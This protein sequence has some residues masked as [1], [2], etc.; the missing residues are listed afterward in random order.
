MYSEKKVA[1]R[2]ALAEKEL[3]ISLEY[4]DTS[5][6][7]RFESYLRENSM[8]I[9]DE[10]GNPTA[11]QNLNDFATRWMLN[12][13]AL[14]LCDAA[15]CL[16]RYAYVKDEKNVIRRFRFRVPQRI[17]FDII[18][19]LEDRNAAIEILDLKARQLGSSTEFELL[20]GHRIFFSYGANAVIGS[21]DE[22]MTGRMSQMLY[23]FYDSMPIWL[24]PQW[25][26]RAAAGKGL[27]EFG[28]LSTGVSFQH[29]AQKHG[30][31]TGTTPT[32]YHLSEAAL[33]EAIG[34]RE[35]VIALIEEGLWKAVHAS[36]NV[37][38]AI[39][40]TGRGDKGWFADTWRYSKKNWPNC[41]MC[42]IFLPWFTGVD[43][44]PTSTWIETHPI[45]ASWRPNPDTVQHVAKCEL[46]VASEPLLRK[47]LLAEQHRGTIQWNRPHSSGEWRMPREQQWF[48]ECG[49][50]EAKAKGTQGSWYQEMAADDVEALQRSGGEPVFGHDTI[51]AI[52]RSRTRQYRC[53]GIAGQS[54][55][56]VHEP[57]PE[58]IDYKQERKVIRYRSPKGEQYKWELIPMAVEPDESSQDSPA[59]LL[60]EFEPPAPRISYSIGVDTSQGK[61]EDST[62][63]SVWA[64][65]WDTSPDRQVAEFSSPFV[66]HTEAFSFILAIAAYYG[67]HM[68][69]G[70][71]KW[72]EPYVSIE[73]VAAVGDVAQAQMVRMGYSNFHRA[74]RYDSRSLGRLKR[75]SRKLGWY[76]YGW[77][78]PILL[79]I[80]VHWAKNQWAEVNSPWLLYE[81]QHFEITT[82]ASGKE[83]MEHEEDEHD[84]RIF[85]AAMAIFCP[86]DM[87]RMDHRSKKRSREDLEEKE[88]DVGEYGV[89]PP[90]S[91]GP[92]GPGSGE[93]G[94]PG[95]V[96]SSSALRQSAVL[97]LEEMIFRGRS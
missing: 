58:Y 80:F 38:G 21:A 4:H 33:Y 66:S 50:E 3:G 10:R 70:E 41:R 79:G 77:S 13:Q 11:L 40:T 71:T 29:G 14:C 89:L 48:W 69:L 35:K 73:Q 8:Y 19:E 54:I 47:H 60:I 56:S 57:Q 86:H 82:T 34:G 55:E 84:D 25:T 9:L 92:R 37:F 39:E 15:Y 67:Q 53:W 49:H 23:L 20:I 83:K 87:D 18:A 2:I 81:M 63:I 26:R 61:G 5:E 52:E 93:G 64:L 94:P 16:T 59:G 62:V 88:I 6:V 12:E 17:L 95:L 51:E 24:R 72:K 31:G 22:A 36:P 90:S 43:I 46:Y 1:E 28:A 74:I 75:H 85:A 42:P 32:L 45:P 27:L 7:D 44:Y 96:I 30:I 76:T 68:R 97:S 78:R 91:S 65:G